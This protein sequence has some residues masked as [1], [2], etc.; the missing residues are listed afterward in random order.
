MPGPDT[1]NRGYTTVDLD[2][3]PANLESAINVPLGEIDADVEAVDNAAQAASAAAATTA[4]QGGTFVGMVVH[5]AGTGDLI[6]ADQEWMRPDGRLIDRTAYATYFGRVGHAHNG[7]VDP[8][9]N[10]VR[11]PDYRGRTLVAP[12]DLGSGAAGRLPNSQRARGQSGGAEMHSHIVDAHQHDMSHTHTF[13]TGNNSSLIQRKDGTG[14]SFNA[15]ADPHIH[16]G[17]TTGPNTTLTGNASPG[18]DQ[19]SLMQP[20][21]VDSCL[22]RV[23]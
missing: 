16:S 2:D 10:M 14:A 3:T 15:A 13:N 7:G 19:R 11:L 17:S 9:G 6:T 21:A 20:Y 8:G 1:P 5:D 18:T 22:V 4:R 12:D 23:K